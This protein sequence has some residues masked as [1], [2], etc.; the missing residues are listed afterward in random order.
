MPTPTTTPEVHR[1][2]TSTTRVQPI[3]S[4]KSQFRML[5]TD[6]IHPDPKQPRLE[7]TNVAGLQ[8]SI[9]SVGLLEPI[10]VR[11]RQPEGGYW[12]VSGERR[13]T[14]VVNLGWELIPSFIRED[15]LDPEAAH[16][17]AGI[18]NLH[19]EDMS[20]LDEA[21]YLHWL[22]H[23]RYKF[24]SAKPLAKLVGH[25]EPWV[26]DRLVLLYLDEN[27]QE[28]LRTGRIK[29]GE[30]VDK[31]REITGRR[32]GPRKDVVLP[33]RT[34][35]PEPAAQLARGFASGADL[36]RP[37]APAPPPAAY[38]APFQVPGQDAPATPLPPSDRQ[39]LLRSI[40]L[41]AIRAGR[42][43][44]PD[45]SDDDIAAEVLAAVAQRWT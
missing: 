25:S 18:A 23:K 39:A 17:L 35:R 27:W 7:L 34:P 32:Y 14:A 8:T 41:T 44:S 26:N 33:K 9:A 37:L 31:A 24:T 21:A 20:P 13:W 2:S 15:I 38:R 45:R 10:V 28:K 29:L 12:I 19:R 36:S 22:W 11:I 16:E 40:V 4:G 43:A 3:T 5:P 6:V 30:A 42:D 1:M